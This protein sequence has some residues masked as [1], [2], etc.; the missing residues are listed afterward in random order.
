MVTGD[1]NDEYGS[2]VYYID[3]GTHFE[4]SGMNCQDADVD[5]IS[6]IESEVKTENIHRKQEQH[7]GYKPW[8]DS[9]PDLER[10][11]HQ[12]HY[13]DDHEILQ[14]L[15]LTGGLNPTGREQLWLDRRWE[16]GQSSTGPGQRE[17]ISYLK[18]TAGSIPLPQYGNRKYC[19]QGMTVGG[20]QQAIAITGLW[21]WPCLSLGSYEFF[22]FSDLVPK[23]ASGEPEEWGSIVTKPIA[24]YANHPS[25]VALLR[26]WM[27]DCETDHSHCQQAKSTGG[28]SPSR[29]I[30][31]GSPDGSQ[32][33]CLRVYENQEDMP[34]TILSHSWEDC[35]AS[36]I[37]ILSASNLD[38]M[39]PSINIEDLAQSFQ[40][41]ITI[42]RILGFQYLWID[43]LCIIQDP[44]NDLAAE[45]AKRLQYFSHSKLS[46][47]ATASANPHEGILQPRAI[48]SAS[49]K[50]ADEASDLGIRPLADDIFYLIQVGRYLP[51]PKR[52]P[53]SDQPLIS[54]AHAF[55]E[56]I[57]ATRTVHFTE[58]QMVW[59]CETCLVGE[60]GQIG[61]HRDRFHE[62][63]GGRSPFDFHL[64]PPMREITSANE[65]EHHRYP[66]PDMG[67]SSPIE[68]HTGVKYSLDEALM[69]T[70]WYDL[71]KEYS[72]RTINKA[73][74][75]LP[76]LSPLASRTHK[77]TIAKYLAGL[78]ALDGESH[79][80]LFSGTV[81]KE[82][83]RHRT[84]RTKPFKKVINAFSTRAPGGHLVGR[85][86]VFSVG[87]RASGASDKQGFENENAGVGHSE[88]C[89]RGSQQDD[90]FAE[91][92]AH[93]SV[94]KNAD[95]PEEESQ[96]ESDEESGR[97]AEEEEDQESIEEGIEKALKIEEIPDKDDEGNMK[98]SKPKEFTLAEYLDTSDPSDYQ[99]EKEKYL[100]L[101]VAEFRD[102]L[103]GTL[104]L[105]MAPKDSIEF[106]ILRRVAS[107]N[108]TDR[109]ARIGTASLKRKNRELGW[110]GAG[111]WGVHSACTEENG[112][113][114]KKLVIVWWYSCSLQSL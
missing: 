73:E 11:W 30:D 65:N 109:Y 60:D 3:Y 62:L 32:S 98:V 31:V 29:L 21:R 53:L 22:N 44:P 36:T 110:G 103:D 5:L 41:A 52:S 114:R 108:D 79:S 91:K 101:L 57:T 48:T 20:D 90:N 86:S 89:S 69:D 15:F 24:C 78:W 68:G 102:K 23:N 18:L 25:T 71:L 38:S 95:W 70:N 19:Y 13:F 50:L 61:E 51:F 113:I 97:E 34:Y 74:N 47:A 63:G 33:P 28:V 16:P 82:A 12:N 67:L 64:R 85:R 81:R 96:D 17:P 107:A 99:W 75:I 39:Q 2:K 8:Y 42:T 4:I 55:L 37:L 9:S 46:I 84:C 56:R 43:A 35:D 1:E 45:D 66:D 72:K 87:S 14:W 54:K 6:K 93:E 76:Y 58:Q 77:Q 83:G 49:T 112:W 92:T 105:H 94:E 104:K 7:H 111:L 59:Q 10:G 80:D 26:Q 27:A 100:L 106:L 40:D 88:R